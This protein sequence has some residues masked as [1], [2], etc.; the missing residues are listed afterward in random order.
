MEE[1]WRRVVAWYVA[2]TPPGTLLLPPGASEDA[3]R[4]AERQLGLKLPPD[5]RA[6][7]RFNDGLGGKWLLHYGEFFSLAGLVDAWQAHRSLEQSQRAQMARGGWVP[8]DLTGPIRPVWWSPRRIQITGIGGTDGLMTDLDP[9]AGGVSGQLIEFDHEVG[10]RR[11]LAPNFTAWLERIAA[12]LEADR[13]ECDPFGSEV[14]PRGYYE[15][16]ESLS[17]WERDLA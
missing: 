15:R 6:F 5:L 2:N 4:T 13:F 14:V 9:A 12:G 1:A 7:Y 16:R 10:P 11:V 17:D 3:V 8:V